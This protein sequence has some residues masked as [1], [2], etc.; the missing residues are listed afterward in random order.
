MLI[1]S[2]KGCIM[3]FFDNVDKDLLLQVP[4]EYRN[5]QKERDGNK[6]HI[7][8][9]NPEEKSIDIPDTEIEDTFLVLSNFL[10]A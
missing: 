10:V 8:I 4:E 7:T 3:T 9:V 6:F 5:K 2:S 1:K